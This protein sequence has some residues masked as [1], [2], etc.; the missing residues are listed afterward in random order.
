ML[1]GIESIDFGHINFES[2]K[3]GVELWCN[4]T[5]IYSYD[6][7]EMDVSVHDEQV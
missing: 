6:R 7:T 5:N 4:A 1:F 2:V 3:W